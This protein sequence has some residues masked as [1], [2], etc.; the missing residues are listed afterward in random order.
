MMRTRK[1]VLAAFACLAILTLSSCGEKKEKDKLQDRIDN[2]KE[3][4]E[5]AKEKVENALDDAKDQIKEGS[6]EAQKAMDK[7]KK[8]LEKR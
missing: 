3:K 5:V 2:A 8:D 7:A 4:V 1:Q 6:K